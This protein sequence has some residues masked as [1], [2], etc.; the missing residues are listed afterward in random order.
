MKRPL[1]PVAAALLFGTGVMAHAAKPVANP[2]KIEEYT[3]LQI[4]LDNAN[5]GPGK[6]DGQSGGNHV[7]RVEQ[8]GHRDSWNERSGFHWSLGE[9]RLHPPG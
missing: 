5:F 3:R 7:D 8:K 1:L 6:I 9:S 4:F 2:N